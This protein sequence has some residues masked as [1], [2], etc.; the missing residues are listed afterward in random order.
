MKELKLAIEKL[1]KL[2][3]ICE[4]NINFEIVDIISLLKNVEKSDFDNY[5]RKNKERIEN[6][7]I[8]FDQNPIT[9]NFNQFLRWRFR[10]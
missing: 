9:S 10:K 8:E 4:P 3:W 5:D 1:E 7:L 6:V 2:Q